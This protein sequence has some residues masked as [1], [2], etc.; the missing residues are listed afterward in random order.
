MPRQYLRVNIYIPGLGFKPSQSIN[1]S[2]VQPD[3]VDFP[4]IVGLSYREAK[5]YNQS[6]E[7][8]KQAID[9]YEDPPYWHDMGIAYYRQKKWEDAKKSFEKSL[10]LDEKYY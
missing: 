6:I 7:L 9:Q 10:V 5:K 8:Y 2:Y 3:P 4:D 1:P